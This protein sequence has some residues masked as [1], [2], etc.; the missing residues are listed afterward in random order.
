MRTTD[1][2]GRESGARVVTHDMPEHIVRDMLVF[3]AQHVADAGDL[4]PWNFRVP[5]FQFIAEM[6]AGFGDDFN[7]ALDQPAFA[8]VRFEGLQRSRRP[9]R[10]G[11][12]QS[13]PR[14]R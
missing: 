7:A 3:M 9:S 4:R 13:P 2:M 14:C 6:P 1:Y 8:L 12:A 11:S 5:A 10:C